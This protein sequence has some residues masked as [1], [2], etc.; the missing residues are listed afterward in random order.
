MEL[1]EKERR[2]DREKAEKKKLHKEKVGLVAAS[3][4]SESNDSSSDSDSEDKKKKKKRKEKKKKH[5][6]EKKSSKKHKKKKKRK[7]R[8][9]SSSENVS[10]SEEEK[11]KKKKSRKSEKASEDEEEW[12]P[13]TK[14]MKK[15][16][17][18]KAKE[19]EMGIIGPAIPEHL[20]K[21]ADEPMVDFQFKNDASMKKDMLRGEAEA[22]AAYI[23]QGK[24]I[25]RRGEIGLS[26]D[27]ITSFE[28]VGYVMSG[29][30]HKAME[31]TRL[32]KEN[33][34]MTAEEKRMLSGFTHEQR[35]QKEDVVL[36][37]MRTLID[38]KKSKEQQN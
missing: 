1:E 14:E 26:S 28:K 9:S 24:R 29:T 20:I 25:P 16:E 7:R 8:H 35:K 21:N 34:I 18:Q 27:E 11:G 10:E 17:E 22:M 15:E 5:K 13:V 4:A 19:E 2:K 23:A 36:Q 30:R 6:K 32:R 31:A 33:Q 3:S 12:V 37:K 38:S